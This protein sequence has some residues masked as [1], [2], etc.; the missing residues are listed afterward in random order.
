MGKRNMLQQFIDAQREIQTKRRAESNERM[1]SENAEINA[2]DRLIEEAEEFMANG[3][4]KKG[5]E[6]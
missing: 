1:Q 2:T 3:I 6:K 4:D 5:Q